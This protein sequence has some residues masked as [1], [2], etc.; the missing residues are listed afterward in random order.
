MT[1]AASDVKIVTD[2]FER[3]KTEE[4]RN[5]LYVQFHQYYL[6]VQRSRFV[7]SNLS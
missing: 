5:T 7:V 3:L 1:A 4:E 2:I 6:A